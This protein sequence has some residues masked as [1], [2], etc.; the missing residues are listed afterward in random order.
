[1]RPSHQLV[2]G[3]FVVLL[4]G[5]CEKK[6]EEAPAPQPVETSGA[7]VERPSAGG[8]VKPT[9]DRAQLA[10]FA[11][12]P[13]KLERPDN[14]ITADKVAL[15]K[16][17]YFD[18]RLSAGKDVSC[19]SCHDLSKAGTDGATVSTGTKKVAGKLNTPT[20]LD[21][22]G[23]I[24]Q[25]WDSRA[26][27]VEAFV[28]PHMVDPT[29]MAMG[30][31]KRAV[32]AVSAIP[33]YAAAFKKA[34]PE[35]KGAVTAD[36]VSKAF[37]AYLR[38]LLTPSRWDKFLA[39]DES[40]L[41]DEEK[42]GLGAFMDAACTTCHAGAYV[43]GAMNQKLGLAKPWP[44]PAGADPGRFAITNEAAEKGMWKVPTLRNVTK[45]A[46]YLH[47]GSMKTLDETV[48]LM[49]RHQVGKELG[50]GQVR[51]ISAFLVAL[52][53]EPPK[54]LVAKPEGTKKP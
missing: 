25:G 46:P 21:A 27:T 45:T 10:I 34:F 1:M 41:T 52:E 51:A 54:D 43:G 6:K 50:D 24:A 53:G 16:Q 44:G 2:L 3:S 12:L 22:A 11:P 29:I 5:A 32:A 40:A 35:E 37:G 17:L 47:D 8:A 7:I 36:M 4:A 48:R 38:G 33:A 31:D 28:V 15:G 39:G 23:Q 49:A 14:P 18:A 19:N 9:F 20:V 26:P 13:A 30:D 42:G